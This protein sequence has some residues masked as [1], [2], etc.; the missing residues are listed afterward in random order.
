MDAAI[1]FS[2]DIVPLGD[3]KINPGRIVRQTTDTKRPVLLTNRGK[4]VAVVQ[5]LE[6]YEAAKE[7]LAFMRAIAKGMADID[8]ERIVPLEDIKSEFADELK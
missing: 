3:L 7:E 5:S 8:A 4:G 2:Q 6:T 1:Q